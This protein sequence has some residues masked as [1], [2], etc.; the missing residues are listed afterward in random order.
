MSNFGASSID[1]PKPKAFKHA[2]TEVV[3]E[4]EESDGAEEEARKLALMISSSGRTDYS[5]N[6]HTFFKHPQF[7]SAQ[8]SPKAKNAPTSDQKPQL[9][10]FIKKTNHTKNYSSI[11]SAHKQ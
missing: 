5:P 11:F 10:G 4:D 9:W 6:S 3:E 2:K 1:V 8:T 7:K